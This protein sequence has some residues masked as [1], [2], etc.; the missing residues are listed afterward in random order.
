MATPMWSRDGVPMCQ[1]ICPHHDG[2]RCRLMGVQ[3]STVCEPVVAAMADILSTSDE[4]GKLC[5]QGWKGKK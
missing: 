5:K 1:E 2:K 3:P 4:A